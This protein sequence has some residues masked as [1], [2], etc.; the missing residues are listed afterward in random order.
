VTAGKVLVVLPTLGDR[1]A[2]LRQTLATVDAQR[3]E[4]ELTLAVVLPAGASDAR[5][6]A[7]EHGAVVVVDPRRGISEAI[8]AGIGAATD[9]T[10]YA[11][12]GDDDL[13]RPGGLDTLRRM[14][15][16]DPGAVLAYGGCE[17]ID[18]EGRVIGT[19]AAGRLAQFLLP[20]GPC[21][22]PHPGSMIRL[23]AMRSVGLFDPELRYAMDLDMFLRLRGEGRFRCTKAAVSA[24]RWHPDSLTVSNRKGSSDEAARVKARHLPGW[25]RPISPLWQEPVKVAAAVAARGVSRRARALAAGAGGAS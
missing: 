14:L 2:H 21:L 5:A 23:D 4:V 18:P 25:I 24:F 15:E 16:R 3:A 20:W 1:L 10:Y 11:W 8:N 7:E 6:L 13:Y 9:E 19:S 22:I 12:M 17:Y